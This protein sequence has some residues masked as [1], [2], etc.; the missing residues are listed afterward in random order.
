MPA[1]MIVRPSVW[2]TLALTTCSSES[3]RIAA[4]V[5][6]HAVED[7]DRVV[8]RVAGDRQDGRDDVQRQVVAEERQERQRDQDVVERRDDG[9]DREA[10]PEAERDV[11]GDAEDARPASPDALALQVRAD[12]R[13]D[14]FRADD[15]ELAEVRL[16][17][18]R[19]RPASTS[20]VEERALLLRLR[21]RQPD[22]DLA[23]RGRAVLLDDL[24]AGHRCRGPSGPRPR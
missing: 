2:L 9:A 24:L 3:R 23:G 4:Q 1:V 11:D 14:D 22:E 10:E 13:A 6:A 8:D 18:R 19:R 16:P 5:L 21:L 15:L 7:D 12:D 17:Q 20:C